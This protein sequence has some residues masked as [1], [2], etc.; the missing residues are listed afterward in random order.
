MNS[1]SDSRWSWSAS[2]CENT[3]HLREHKPTF[4]QC[5][6]YSGALLRRRGRYLQQLAFCD[7]SVARGALLV[8]PPIHGVWMHGVGQ[9]T[10]RGCRG[11][12]GMEVHDIPVSDNAALRLVDT[13]SEH[14]CVR[15]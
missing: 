2:N 3:S 15:T 9:T 4:I 14:A 10:W 5:R 8:R 6:R 13:S 7:D 12:Q 1:S 11:V